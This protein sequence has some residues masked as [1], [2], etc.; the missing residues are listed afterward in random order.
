MPGKTWRHCCAMAIDTAIDM[1][2]SI[3]TWSRTAMKWYHSFKNNG[4]LLSLPYIPDEH[5]L[6]PFLQQNHDI[7]IRI[8]EYARLNIHRLSTQLILEYLH[9]TII[10]E[11]KKERPNPDSKSAE[12]LTRELLHDYGLSTLSMG[13]VCRWMNRLGFKYC[14][15]KKSYY[16]DGHERQGTISYRKD[17]VRR[18]LCYERRTYRWIQITKNEH[19]Y[20]VL[21]GN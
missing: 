13:T 2:L 4:R 3:S 21:Q 7:V 9:D 18:Y 1:G 20:L 17:F 16:V 12:D 19:D 14:L 8:K 6:H 10:P 11:M 5:K 15:R